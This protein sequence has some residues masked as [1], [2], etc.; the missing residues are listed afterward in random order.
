[1]NA[2]KA[3]MEK[4]KARANGE[5]KG[6]IPRTVRV[7][8]FVCILYGPLIVEKNQVNCVLMVV[9][10]F[11]WRGWYR[12]LFGN[13]KLYAGRAWYITL[14]KVLCWVCLALLLLIVVV[15]LIRKFYNDA[16]VYGII[17]YVSV[18]TVVGLNLTVF[19]LIVKFESKLE[20][21]DQ[22]KKEQVPP[23]GKQ[24]ADAPRLLFTAH[25]STAL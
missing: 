8:F 9:L 22:Q 19:A 20:K 11:L 7:A 24:P 5:L 14:C 18:G 17:A 25:F 16:I 3:W 2:F 21:E 12:Y 13:I 4:R 15:N 23:Q 10:G 1:M 6:C